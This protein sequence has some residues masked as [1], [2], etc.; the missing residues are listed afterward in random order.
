MGEL[1]MVSTKSDVYS[2]IESMSDTDF[3]ELCVY[4]NST[5]D[6]AEKRRQAEERF[7]SEVKAAETSVSEGNYISLSQLHEFLNV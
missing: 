2:L 7:V 5:Y 4:L 6:K 1:A 3:S